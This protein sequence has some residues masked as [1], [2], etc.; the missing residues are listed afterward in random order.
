MVFSLSRKTMSLPL[1][2]KLNVDDNDNA[3]GTTRREERSKSY[4]IEPQRES[5]QLCPSRIQP[6]PNLARAK[7]CPSQT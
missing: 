5:R 1:Y 7:L 3:N 2:S 6:E 4:F